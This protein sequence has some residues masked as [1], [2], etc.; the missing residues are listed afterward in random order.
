MRRRTIIS[1]GVGIALSGCLSGI[2]EPQK[3]IDWIRLVNERSEAYTIDVIIEEDGEEIFADEYEVG[4][5]PEL[6]TISVAPP[7]TRK[8]SYVLRFRA[9]GQWVHIYPEEYADVRKGC[10]GIHF[11]LHQQETQRFDIQ[12]GTDC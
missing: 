10:I 7:L 8:G 1:L 11:E 12:P 5:T 3:Q 6:S 2:N 4:T 9:D